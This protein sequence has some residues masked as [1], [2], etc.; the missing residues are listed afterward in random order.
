MSG[1]RDAF[2]PDDVD[3]ATLLALIG[4]VAWARRFETALQELID[5]EATAEG[6]HPGGQGPDP[7]PHEPTLRALL[8]LSSLCRQLVAL[9]P[10]PSAQVELPVAPAGRLLR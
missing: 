5:G 10:G 9:D 4:A 7:T 8:G 6:A 3:D 1:L 2:V